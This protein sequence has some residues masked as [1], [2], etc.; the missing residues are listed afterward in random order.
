MS[1]AAASPPSAD[2]AP[3]A[4]PSEPQ[5]APREGWFARY[6]VVWVPLA[7]AVVVFGAIL[8][9]ALVGSGGTS[10]EVDTTSSAYQN[11]YQAGLIVRRSGSIDVSFITTMCREAMMN[12]QLENGNW[13]SE[14]ERD[15]LA[16]CVAGAQDQ[17]TP[18]N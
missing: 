17:I 14:Q 13:T 15:A 5:A 1:D 8:V 16:G 4:P 10:N 18:P 6:K 3:L 12:A 11:G 7:T 2:D 9:L